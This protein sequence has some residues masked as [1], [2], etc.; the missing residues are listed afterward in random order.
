[1]TMRRI[2]H[3]AAIS[4]F[5]A[6][7]N[8]DCGETA[9]ICALHVINPDKYALDSAELARVVR[10]D[11]DHGWASA[12]GAEPISGIASDLALEGVNHTNYG[13]SQPA[14]F[15]WRGVLHQWGGLKPLIFEFAQAG[16]LPGDEAGV[17]FHFIACLGWDPDANTG[18]FADGDNQ[19]VRQGRSG[20]AGLVRYTLANLEAAQ[21]CGLIIAEYVLGEPPVMTT[22]ITIP[23]GWKDDGATLT[24]PNGVPVVRGFRDYILAHPTWAATNWPLAPESAVGQLE[25]GNPELGGGSQQFFRGTVLEWRPASAGGDGGPTGVFQAPVGQELT[26]TRAALTIATSQLTAANATISSLQ[27]QLAALQQQIATLQEQVATL[28]QQLS[29]LQPPAPAP[30][31]AG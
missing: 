23:T 2:P 7:Y 21:V 22:T 29:A 14:R 27:Q 20:P 5:C 16:A 10:R 17:H 24:A 11:I 26:A 28:Q 18:V 6:S 15:D 13:F 4:E 25:L 19:I 1:M 9:E 30:P 12:N 8:G 31:T 3:A